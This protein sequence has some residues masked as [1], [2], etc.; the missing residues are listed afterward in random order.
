MILCRI[1]AR[2][3]LLWYPVLPWSTKVFGQLVGVLMLLLPL[4][5]NCASKPVLIFGS[6]MQVEA[7]K[8]SKLE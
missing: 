7:V 4:T 1:L 3:S 2:V 8:P 6:D 5:R